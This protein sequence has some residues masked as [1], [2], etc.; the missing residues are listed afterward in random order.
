MFFN[1]NV[2]SK[3]PT[4]ISMPIGTLLELC[5]HPNLPCLVKLALNLKVHESDFVPL[6]DGTIKRRSLA[7]RKLLE[8]RCQTQFMEGHSPAQFRCKSN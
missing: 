5:S 8:Q 3:S 7:E 1:L 2:V 6:W 4:E